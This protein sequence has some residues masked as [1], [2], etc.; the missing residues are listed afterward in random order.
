MKG[1]RERK[2]DVC[3]VLAVGNRCVSHGGRR[4]R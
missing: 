3:I 1:G 2:R 4:G